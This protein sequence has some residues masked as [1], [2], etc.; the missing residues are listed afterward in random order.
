M[1]N[2]SPKY[3][4]FSYLEI[5]RFISV[6]PLQFK[7]PIYTPFQYAGNKPVSYID[8]DGAEEVEAALFVLK[9]LSSWTEAI[10]SLGISFEAKVGFPLASAGA[11]FGAYLAADKY[12]NYAFLGTRAA[13]ASFFKDGTSIAPEYNGRPGLFNDGSNY[14]GFDIGMSLDLAVKWG[15][16]FSH[17]QHLSGGEENIDIDVGLALSPDVSFIIK[18]ENTVKKLQ[19]IELSGGIGLGAGGGTTNAISTIYAFT[20][21][22]LEIYNEKLKLAEN[23]KNKLIENRVQNIQISLKTRT[24]EDGFVLSLSLTGHT[25]EGMIEYSTYPIMRFYKIKDDYY[26][27]GTVVDID[28]SE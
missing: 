28:K 3:E 18:R 14:N 16:D 1:I 8:L 13:F 17:V 20:D 2:C 6:D 26:K 24:L 7:Y 9:K 5:A 11:T 10:W 19:G 4:N 21:S 12:G 25:L 15:E 23:Y 22:D 27:T